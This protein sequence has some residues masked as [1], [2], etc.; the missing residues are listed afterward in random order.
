VVEEAVFVLRMAGV[1]ASGLVRTTLRRDVASLIVEE[2]ERWSADAVLVGAPHRRGVGRLL[3]HGV[4]DQVIRRSSR[5]VL[6]APAC[7]LVVMAHAMVEGV[8]D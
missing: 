1:G 6:V 7:A 5:P 4:R 8:P 2:S 3:S